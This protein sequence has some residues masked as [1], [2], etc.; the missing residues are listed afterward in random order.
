LPA[1]T[2][3]ADA[4]VQS[5]KVVKL[6]ELNAALPAGFRQVTAVERRQLVEQRA[7]A[8]AHRYAAAPT[9]AGLVDPR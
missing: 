7:A 4:A 9:V 3:T 5:V 2:T 1:T 8:Y 6:R